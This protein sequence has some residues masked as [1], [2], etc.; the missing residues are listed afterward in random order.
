MI[1]REGL[2]QLDGS[3]R[4][5][6][7]ELFKI[8]AER[9]RGEDF[10][11]G[12]A[13]SLQESGAEAARAFRELRA[14]LLA[15]FVESEKEGKVTLRPPFRRD[16]FAAGEEEYAWRVRNVLRVE[17]PVASL[18]ERAARLVANE[19]ERL[20]GA[21]RRVAAR[22]GLDLPWTT[23]GERSAST[24]RVFSELAKESPQNDAEL[25]GWFRDRCDK[26]VAFARRN[27]MFDIPEGYRLDVVPTPPT[28]EKSLDGGSYFPAPPFKASGVGRLYLNPTHGDRE[29][30]KRSNRSAIADD[31]VHEGFP[32]HDWHFKVMTRYRSEIPP[33]RWLTPDEVE[34]SSSAWVDSMAVE[35]WAHY[36]ETL[37]AEPQPKGREGYYSPEES[38]YVLRGALYRNLRVRIDIGLHTGRLSYDDAVDLFS[39]TTDFL[40]GSCRDAKRSSEKR[41]SCDSAESAIYRYSKWPT[42][43]IT[44]RLGKERILAMREEALKIVPGKEGEKRFH[45]LYMRHGPV[46]PDLFRGAL[47]EEMRRGAEKSPPS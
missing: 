28:L 44:Y 37:M 15:S 11:A 32:G 33:V 41:A 39:E 35:G 46:P 10:S 9:T 30:L 40:P 22:R 43:A 3:S 6:G 13:A 2:H 1:V 45:L 38:L 18:Y 34:G 29:K 19:R 26:L 42:Q 31:A 24:R 23:A 47:L 5:F 16:R 14:F 4:Y 7:E 12:L 25:L 17:E 36:A 27:G 20:I 8:A 21:A